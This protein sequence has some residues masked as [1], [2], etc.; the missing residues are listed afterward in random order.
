MF[1]GGQGSE[2]A[3]EADGKHPILWRQVLVIKA[4]G[5]PSAHTLS[6]SHEAVGQ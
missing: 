3:V 2:A 6:S 1:A 5:G 4:D